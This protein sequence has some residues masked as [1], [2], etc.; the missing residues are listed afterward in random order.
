M[1]KEQH[2]EDDLIKQLIEQ[3][4]NYRPDIR[5]RESL[6]K[7]FKEK[8][9]ALNRVKLSDNEFNRLKEE[10]IQP[11]EFKAAKILRNRNTF[12]R[13]DST[14]LQYTLVNIK[15]WCRNDFEVI[16]QLRM[17]TEDSNHRYDVI[18]LLNGLR[19]AHVERCNRL[20]TTKMIP[21]TAIK[22][23]CFV[24]CNCLLLVIAAI[25]IILPITAISILFL[26][27]MSNSYLFTN[28]RTI[29]TKK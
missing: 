12:Y 13:E 20:W 26:M 14:P 23:R 18:L 7:N 25:H 19:L 6:E 22:T 17:N 1:T 28:M 9:E 3:K 10:I 21:V 29:K 24:L 2:I 15:D 11:D 4:Y 5:N 16:N 8:F 27:P